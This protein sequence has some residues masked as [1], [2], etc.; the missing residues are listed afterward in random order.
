MDLTLRNEC[1]KKMDELEKHKISE[2]FADPID[3]IQDGYSDYYEVIKTPM[4]LSIVR[5]KLMKNVYKSVKEWKDD[6]E[7]IWTNTFTYFGEDSYM[8][9]NATELQKIFRKITF[10]FSDSPSDDWQNGLALL[11]DEYTRAIKSLSQATPFLKKR[12]PTFASLTSPSLE[13]EE[14]FIFTYDDIK[15]LGEDIKAFN[16]ADKAKIREFLKLYEPQFFTKKSETHVNLSSLAPT[17]LN[18]L[19]DEVDA[20]I[21]DHEEL[22]Q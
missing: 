7:L 10:S 17:T 1:L 18:A 4:D 19:R 15:K 11:C 5:Q 3:P 9:D 13:T 16:A 14:N 8:L 12:S 2:L 22:G 6:V 21:F 20:I